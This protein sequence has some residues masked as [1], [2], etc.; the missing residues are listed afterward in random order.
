MKDMFRIHDNELITNKHFPVKAL[1]DM[2][3]DD[4]FKY[5]M[6]SI[7]NNHGFAENYGACLFWNDLDDYEKENN[8]FYNGAEFGL[9]SGEEVILDY[10]EILYYMKLVCKR[11]CVEHPED[12]NELM[13]C[14]QKFIDNNSL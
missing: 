9:H 6:H 12:C 5:V 2:V 4:R 1:F 10:K 11:Y 8:L 3:S 14:I 13:E 7:S